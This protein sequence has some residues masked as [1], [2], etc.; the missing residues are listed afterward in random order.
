MSSPSLYFS[1]IPPQASWAS[2]SKSLSRKT[3]SRHMCVLWAWMC[4]RLYAWVSQPWSKWYYLIFCTDLSNNWRLIHLMMTVFI[5]DWEQKSYLIIVFIFGDWIYLVTGN[6]NL[7]STYPYVGALCMM[8][9]RNIKLSLWL[10]LLEIYLCHDWIYWFYLAN[11]LFV[12]R[13]IGD[14][15]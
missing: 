14:V 13:F 1:M 6:M 5:G 11:W 10:G 15:S 9:M 3:V 8:M 12:I 7:F 4:G 2:I